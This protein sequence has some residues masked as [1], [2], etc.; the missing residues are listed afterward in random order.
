MFAK[1][2]IVKIINISQSSNVWSQLKKDFIRA[3]TQ[4]YTKYENKDVK[5][6]WKYLLSDSSDLFSVVFELKLNRNK[7]A[8]KAE[9]SKLSV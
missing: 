7:I 5:A 9:K 2:H 1:Y 6:V 4:N 3:P 8:L